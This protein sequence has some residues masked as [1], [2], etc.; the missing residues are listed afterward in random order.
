MLQNSIFNSVLLESFMTGFPLQ[1]VHLAVLL[2]QRY[3]MG[4][5]TTIISLLIFIQVFIRYF[6]DI[7][8][9][10]VEEIAAYLAVWLYF[11]GSGYGIYQGNHISASVMDLI[12]PTQ[13]ARDIFQVFVS[14]ITFILVC[15]VSILCW[16]YFQWSLKRMPKS[17]ELRL[18][19][20]YV[21]FAMVI[22]LGLMVLYSL[23]EVIRRSIFIAKNEVYI[24]LVTSDENRLKAL[25]SRK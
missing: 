19:L 1:K 15:W 5:S 4:I 25:N 2:F 21:H 11:I 8:L 23:I 10:G 24:A 7:P 13:R 12:L 18:P 16:D 17:P 22:G 9:Y 14:I 6:L 3:L 20:F